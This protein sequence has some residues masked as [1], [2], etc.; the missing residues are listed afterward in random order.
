M[1]LS[2]DELGR[3][4]RPLMPYINTQRIRELAVDAGIYVTLDEA[5]EYSDYE[6]LADLDIFNVE[7]PQWVF[8]GE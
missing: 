3:T 4:T 1:E 7:F 2:P 6:V 8:P 5:W